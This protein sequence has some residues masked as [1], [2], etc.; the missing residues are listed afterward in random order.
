MQ[1]EQTTQDHRLYVIRSLTIIRLPRTKVEMLPFC[2]GISQGGQIN[3][4]QFQVLGLN[5]KR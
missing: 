1:P 4:G 5:N 3:P 2:L